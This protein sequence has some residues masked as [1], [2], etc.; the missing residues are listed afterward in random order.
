MEKRRYWN[1]KEKALSLAG[2]LAT[3]EE[4]MNLAEDRLR[5]ECFCQKL[6]PI[7]VLLAPAGNKAQGKLM[8][9]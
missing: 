9:T 4:A 6:Q 7:F 2:G 1:F 8:D 5:N 3:K